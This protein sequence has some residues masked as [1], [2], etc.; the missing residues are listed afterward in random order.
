MD[1]P[2]GSDEAMEDPYGSDGAMED[3]YGSDGDAVME[4]DQLAKYFLQNAETQ[5]AS[6]LQQLNHQKPIPPAVRSLAKHT[7]PAT[8]P[9]PAKNTIPATA[10]SPANSRSHKN[11]LPD[12]LAS[13]AAKRS[14]PQPPSAIDVASPQKSIQDFF[15][16]SPPKTVPEQ[17]PEASRTTAPETPRKAKATGNLGPDGQAKDKAGGDL[18]W[19]ILLGLSGGLSLCVCVGCCCVEYVTIRGIR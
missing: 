12:V 4:D 7:I 5:A 3:P 15:G 13:P 6:P 9:S 17:K 16:K 14:C 18:K 2:Y 1:D 19:V 11:G 10:P 8:A